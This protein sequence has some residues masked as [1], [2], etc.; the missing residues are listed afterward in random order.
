MTDPRKTKGKPKEQQP[1]G[2]GGMRGNHAGNFF[3]DSNALGHSGLTCMHGVTT[4]G[5]LQQE[6]HDFT[7]PDSCYFFLLQYQIGTP[8]YCQISVPSSHYT[9]MLYRPLCWA[10]RG[11]VHQGEDQVRWDQVGPANTGLFVRRFPLVVAISLHWGKKT[12]QT[13]SQAGRVIPTPWCNTPCR[14][15]VVLARSCTS[16]QIKEFELFSVRAQLMVRQPRLVWL[17]KPGRSKLGTCGSEELMRMPNTHT[18]KQ[19]NSAQCRENAGGKK[20][21][22]SGD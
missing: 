9:S 11:S 6:S 18:H 5:A 12:K 17:R 14:S 8:A 13:S 4:G 1:P 3:S 2:G 21:V 16:R 15:A 19:H 7:P 20:K 10:V 22:G